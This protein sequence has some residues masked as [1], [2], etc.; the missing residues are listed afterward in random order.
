MPSTE[1]FRYV[2]RYEE[3]E[4]ADKIFATLDAYGVD[5]VNGNTFLGMGAFKIV[6][7]TNIPDAVAIISRNIR[8]FDHELL[9]LDLL[10]S[11]GIPA[12]K[13]YSVEKIGSIVIALG[14]RLYAPDDKI[15]NE[16]HRNAVEKEVRKY[17]ISILKSGF[18]MD[19]LQFMANKDGNIVFIDPLS[20]GFVDDGYGFYDGALHIDAR[21]KD[22]R[23]TIG[24]VYAKMERKL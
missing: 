20:F 10:G 9:L 19:D 14:E 17:L 3:S 24:T 16:S 8:Q 15:G 1:I 23:S 13:Y 18:H 11:S 2:R 5:H 6:H 4:V 22:M 21:C 12:M 7:E